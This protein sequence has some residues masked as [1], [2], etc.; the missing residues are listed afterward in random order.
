MSATKKL[1]KT[2]KRTSKKVAGLFDI[3]KSHKKLLFIV[4]IFFLASF[5]FVRIYSLYV[6]GSFRIGGY[7]IHHF[8]F[9]TVALALGGILGILNDSKNKKRL[10]FASA[11]IGIGLG[12]FGDEIGLLLNCTTDNRICDYA[13]PEIGDVIAIIAIIIV[14][15]I[16]IADTD[17]TVFKKLFAKVKIK[18]ATETE[19]EKF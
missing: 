10:D 1:K 8:Y 2:L 18:L 6:G 13:F 7:H 19:I 14:F 15:L 11:L 17:L 12:L 3:R 5:V 4:L 9:G 16:V